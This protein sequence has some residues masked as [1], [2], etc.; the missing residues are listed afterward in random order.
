MKISPSKAAA[1]LPLLDFSNHRQPKK[2][3][4][5]DIFLFNLYVA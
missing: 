5:S 2:L 4:K 1:L 3:D